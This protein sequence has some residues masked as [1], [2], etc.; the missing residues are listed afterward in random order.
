MIEWLFERFGVSDGIFDALLIVWTFCITIACL[1]LFRNLLPHDGGRDFAF[2]GK[3]S[4]GKLRGAG[5]IFI[6]V[7]ALTALLF[8]RFSPEYL[9][10]YVLVFLSML[11]GYLDD[12]SEKPWGEY[13]KGLIDLILCL[14]AAAVFVWFNPALCSVGIGPWQLAIP[15]WLFALILT[16]FFWLMINATNC[17]DGIDGYCGSMSIVVLLSLCLVGRIVEMDGGFMSQ[18]L[19]MILVIGAYLWYNCEPSTMLM[20]DAGSR[21]IGLFIGLAV[22]RTGNVLLCIPLCF[23]ILLDGL[24]GIVKVSL[25][26]FLKINAFKN[27]RTPLHDHFRMKKNWSNT[28]VI[29]RSILLQCVISGVVIA[30]LNV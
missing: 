7:F 1:K 28:Q 17:S 12:R 2:N 20:G 25:I 3:L 26:R 16:V 29:F 8:I 11:S 22:A 24:L 9:A 14:A 30:L 21:A 19:I 4:K 10:Y 27:I 5:I 15:Q 23:V 6:S 13:K 18:M